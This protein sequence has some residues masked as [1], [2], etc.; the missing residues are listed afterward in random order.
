M[1]DERDE[2]AWAGWRRERD[3]ERKQRARE[4]FDRS[5]QWLALR[6]WGI[7]LPVVEAVRQAMWDIR[8]YR[9]A[10][11]QQHGT[12]E[13]EIVAV[14]VTCAVMADEI[15]AAAAARPDLDDTTVRW[16]LAGLRCPM[17]PFCLGCL[18]CQ[19]ITAPT[20]PFDTER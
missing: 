5:E 11:N 18:S 10:N 8:E 2:G 13:Q 19:T 4:G 12:N 17:Q 3:E 14:R 16:V 20:R 15:Q 1:S 6:N 9:N 7:G